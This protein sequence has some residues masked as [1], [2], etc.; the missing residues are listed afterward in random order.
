M[1][2]CLFQHYFSNF[3]T[4]A[5]HSCLCLV[6][7]S[8]LTLCNPMDCSLP[9]SSVIGIIQVRTL[10]WV[11]ISFSRV[12][13]QPRNQ[14][15]VFCIAGRFFTNW[16]TKEALVDSS[17]KATFHVHCIQ[18]AH[19]N[20]TH[21]NFSRVKNWLRFLFSCQVVS[22][23]LQLHR[24]QHIRLCPPLSPGVC[25]SLCPLSQWCY[26]TISSSRPFSFCLQSFPIWVFPNELAL[27]ISWPKYCS[28][29]FSISPSNE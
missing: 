29:S 13:S 6:A 1:C 10:E 24:L 26:L 21:R 12:S 17:T 27:P 16:A 4:Q 7:E 3:L 15:R 9:S 20:I 25:S 11:A 18:K 22:D 8:R 28:F 2:G 5:V 14:T 23:S 19:P